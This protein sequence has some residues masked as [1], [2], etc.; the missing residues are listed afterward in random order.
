MPDLS[1][2][3]ETLASKPLSMETDKLKVQER[4]LK[5]LIDADKYLAGTVASTSA[6]R[7]LR[8]TRLICRG[9]Q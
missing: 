6:R 8:F 9:D 7:G 3:I 5:E 4:S 1:D 2:T